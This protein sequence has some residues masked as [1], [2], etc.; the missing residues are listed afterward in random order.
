MGQSIGIKAYGFGEK[1]DLFDRAVSLGYTEQGAARLADCFTNW[2][3]V[4]D[5][6]V[7]H[8]NHSTSIRDGYAVDGCEACEVIRMTD[9]AGW[10]PAVKPFKMAVIHLSDGATKPPCGLVVKSATMS[11]DTNDVTC[12]KCKGTRRFAAADKSGVEILAGLLSLDGGKIPARVVK[13]APMNPWGPCGP[14]DGTDSPMVRKAHPCGLATPVAIPAGLP[15]TWT[16]WQMDTPEG[17]TQV[18]WVVLTHEAEALRRPD[19]VVVFDGTILAGREHVTLTAWQAM[20]RTGSLRQIDAPAQ[21]CRN[22]GHEYCMNG[23]ALN[24]W[25]LAARRTSRTTVETGQQCSDRIK[26][27]EYRV[28]DLV[29]FATRVG[30]VKH[31]DR[32]WECR[33]TFVCQCGKCDGTPVDDWQHVTEVI[34]W[35]SG[36]LDIRG[37]NG[38]YRSI[39]PDRLD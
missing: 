38:A 28:G 19:G 11:T 18:V 37:A 3:R 8:P 4:T 14:C 15:A 21:P 25:T 31:Q 7:K 24:A 26:R 10:V 1:A 2:D 20:Q 34:S 27:G 30:Y 36:G 17:G 6:C 9:D 32:P 29:N 5:P 33:R 16:F 23:C 35:V 22:N 39:R 12:R 13:A